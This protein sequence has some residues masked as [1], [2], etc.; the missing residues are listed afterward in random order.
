MERLAP[1]I[2]VWTK[3]LEEKKRCYKKAA[4]ANIWN[5]N[6]HTRKFSLDVKYKPTHNPCNRNYVS[7]YI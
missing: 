2:F 1:K 3:T 6:C 5:L 4:E 7:I